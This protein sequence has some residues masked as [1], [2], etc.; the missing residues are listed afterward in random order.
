MGKEKIMPFYGYD[1]SRYKKEY[2]QIGQAIGGVAAVIG[3]EIDE[4]VKAFRNRDDAENAIKGIRAS[5]KKYAQPLIDQKIMTME[6]RD[7]NLK[8]FRNPTDTDFTDP[9][10]YIKEMQGG[11]NE[12]YPPLL[13]RQKQFQ[14]ETTA[15]K[16]FQPARVAHKFGEEGEPTGREELPPTTPSQLVGA[17]GKEIPTAPAEDIMGTRAGFRAEEAQTEQ[18]RQ[19]KVALEKR[20]IA[21]R[22]QAEKGRA[23]RAKEQQRLKGIS[24][25]IQQGRYKVYK[26]E[27]QQKVKLTDIEFFNKHV[28]DLDEELQSLVLLEDMKKDNPIYIAKETDFKKAE[29]DY[30]KMVEQY[31]KSRDIGM[32]TGAGEG[33]AA[34]VTKAHQQL[35]QAEELLAKRDFSRFT[36]QQLRKAIEIA[37]KIIQD[38]GI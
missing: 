18:R 28:K 23:T 22:E 37:R 25:G 15:Q 12:L 9:T 17:V 30:K 13:E 11:A 14:L 35:A 31:K 16:Q 5:Y 29:A 6:E 2:G 19:E 24:I 21:A 8:R 27:A 38:A 1:P 4:A 34:E 33:E 10:A 32:K 3:G 36:E 7:I 20:K 26:S